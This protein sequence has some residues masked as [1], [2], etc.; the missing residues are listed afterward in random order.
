MAI[1][2]ISGPLLAKNLLRDGVDLAFETDLLYLDVKNGR[3]GVRKTN[4]A[5]ELDVNGTINANNLRVT[6]TGPG[7]G[8]ATLG[9][10]TINSGTIST[11]VGPVTIQPS[12]NDRINLVGDTTV[13]GNFHATGNI[14]ADGNIILGNT[15]TDIVV[16]DAEIDSDIIPTPGSNHTL[17]SQDNPW[18]AAFVDSIIANAL[19]NS[20]G[21]MSITPASGLLEINGDIR[22]RTTNPI[23]TAPVVTNVLYVTMDG[24]DTNDGRAEDPSRAC[25]TIGGAIRS[26]YYRPGTMI[27]VRSGRY[28]ENNPLLLQPNTAIVGDDLRT[29][30]IEPINKTQDLFHVQSGC[31]LAQ[32]QFLNGRSGLLPGVYASGSNRG[33]FCAA[34]PPQVSGKKIDVYQS[35]YIQNCTNQSGPWLIDGTMF[36]PNQTVQIPQ[37]VGLTTFE[38]NTNTLVVT[39]STGTIQVGMSINSGPQ[40]QGFLNARTLVLANKEFIKDQV[41]AFVN[42]TYPTFT[43]EQAK[44]ARDVGIIVENVLYDA[45]FGG[46]EKSVEAGLAYYDGVINLIEGQ[47]TQ[48]TAAINYINTLSQYII[49]NEVAPVISTA[50][51]QI[52]N[53]NLT[54]GDVASEE[55]TAGISI[56]AD[57]INNGPSVAPTIFKSSTPDNPLVS[58]EILLQANRTL[59]QEE[60]TAYVDAMYPNH[61]YDRS[62]CYRDVGLIVDAVSQDVLVG[63]NTKSLEAALSYYTGSKGNSSVA[64]QA[65]VNNLELIKKIILEGPSAAPTPVVGPNLGTGY[66]NAQDL[67]ERNTNFIQ[68]EVSAYVRSLFDE[69]FRLTQAQ[70]N[71]CYRDIGLI[72]SAIA[73][74]TGKGGNAKSVEAGLA[75]YNGNVSLLPGDQPTKTAQ[76]IDYLIALSRNIVKNIKNTNLYSTTATQ[77][78]TLAPATFNEVT[79]ATINLDLITDIITSGPDVAAVATPINLELTTNTSAIYAFNILQANRNFLSEEVTGYI[80]DV[81]GKGF[82]YDEYKCY[83]DTGLIVDSL[84]YDLLYQGNTQAIFAGLQYWTQGSSSIPNEQTTTTN[85]INYARDLAKRVIINDVITA[86][87][88]STSQIFDLLNPGDAASTLTVETLFNTVTNIISNG[89][90]GVTNQIIPNVEQSVDTGVLNSYALLQANKSFIENEVIAYVDASNQSFTYNKDLC[91]RDVGLIVDALA[92]DLLFSTSSQATFAG[93]QY[94]NQAGYT[95]DIS[96]E[97]TTTTNAIQYVRDLAVKIV[98]NDTT[99]PRYQTA[100]AQYTTSTSGT[101][102][103][104]QTVYDNF[105]Q[106]LDIL[107]NG[108]IGVSDKIVPNRLTSSTNTNVQN[109][110]ELLQSNKEYIEREAVA[111]VEATK[112]RGFIYDISKCL[113]DVGYMVDS[114]SFDVLYGGNKQS[115]QSGVYYYGFSTTSSAVPNE[116][117]QVTAAYNYIKEISNYII[118]GQRLPT[119]YQNTISQVLSASAGTTTEAALVNASVDNITNIVNTGPAGITPTPISLT[120]STDPNVINGAKLLSANRD[121]LKAEVIAYIDYLYPQG[122]T[123]DRVKCRRDVNYIIDCVSFDLLNGGNRQSIQAGVYYY[124]FNPSSSYLTYEVAQAIAAYNHINYISRDII[125]GIAV[126]TSTGNTATQVI[127]PD[128]GTDVEAEFIA[129]DINII[130]D[131]IANGPSTA[132]PREP[133]ALT[134]SA[135]TNVANAYAQLRANRE[136]IQAE[137]IAYVESNFSQP[138]VFDKLKCTRD[139]KLIIDSIALD[140]IY[141]GNTQSTFAGLQYWAQG[142]SAIPAEETTTTNAISYTKS[143][144]E[145]LVGSVVIAEIIGDRFDLIVNIIQSGTDGVTDIIVPN[146]LPSRNPEIINAYETLISN[147]ASLQQQTV[148]WVNTNNPGFVYNTSTCY[149]DVGYIIECV[150]FDLLHGGNRQSVQAGVYYYG[151]DE[152]NT[153]VPDE[154]PQTTAAYT[155]LKS[156]ITRVLQNQKVNRTYQTIYNQVTEPAYMAETSLIPGEESI[157]ANAITYLNTLSQ[158]VITNTPITKKYTTSTQA[159]Y[160]EFEGGYLAGPAVARNYSIIANI[161]QN[162]PSVAPTAYQGSGLFATTGVSSNDVRESPKVLEITTQT[163]NTYTVKISGVTQ[164][165]VYNGTL[166]FGET[167]VFPIQNA[168][169][170][171]LSLEYTGDATTWDRRKIDPIGAMGGAL[172]D[173]GV[174]SDRSPIQSFVFDAFTQVNQGG[175]GVYVTNNGYAQLVSVFTI[176][177]STAVQ[178]DNGGI[179]SITNSNSNF[180]DQ[181]LVAKGYGKREFSGTVYNPPFP[182]YQPNGEYYPAGFYPKNGLVEIFVPDS[183]NRPHIA[184]VM[185]VEPP[186]NYINEQG[187]SGFLNAAPSMPTLTT[188]TITITGIDT[189]GIAVGNSVFIRDQFGNTSYAA[190]GTTVV[191]VNYQSITLNKGLISGGGDI[192]NPNF[193]NLYFCGNA[194][195]TVL[196]SSLT[197]AYNTTPYDTVI[198]PD[199][200]GPESDAIDYIKTTVAGYLSAASVET[201]SINF[202]NDRFDII[203]QI[204]TATNLT[205]AESVVSNPVKTGTNPVGASLAI[206]TINANIENVVTST[207]S[208]INSTY[209]ALDY[210]Q[211]KCSRDIRLILRQVI[212]DLEFGGNYYSTYAG[213]SYWKRLGTHHVVNLEEAVNNTALFPDGAIVNFY[214]RSYMSASGYLFEYVGAGANYGALPQRGIADPVQTKEVIQLNNGKVFFTSTDQNGDFRIGPGLVVSQST[215]VLSGRT[216][217]KSLFANLTPFILAIEGS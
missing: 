74:D 17:G 91:S 36:V 164:G 183:A 67:L 25:K 68:T 30:S 44:C 93:L 175:R 121:F 126:T 29:T 3:I 94:W 187:F 190:T 7:T 180:G 45:A 129:R 201:A 165:P 35:P 115:I 95:G 23:G 123:Y 57:I 215:G 78:L 66:Y 80:D 212:Y 177:C 148:D 54:G 132:Y 179:C 77:V 96:N 120:P 205:L 153:N 90:A 60:T 4:P 5:Y 210:N 211:D 150:A 42:T 106:I 200:I 176:F 198:P 213:L 118:T 73:E 112:T 142:A 37:A 217:T 40:D 181:C 85:A 34:F 208:Y 116:Q 69:T 6:Y 13:T 12:G 151:F 53:T 48:T 104:S 71:L 158:L 192:D 2:R 56:I 169:A 186:L 124:G 38:A 128:V 117:I 86:L 51:S 160:P 147:K 170:E 64:E 196:S 72:V 138:F 31:Y 20:Q 136:F 189:S 199:Q 103:E 100:V 49:R 75:Y 14:S 89:T 16:F 97:L 98:T 194:Y 24:D 146:G 133:I 110:Y 157:T 119:Q 113:R 139:T 11:T 204:V 161:V 88:T 143:L 58:A 114:V 61:V 55:I 70:Q 166:Y 155:Y 122:F 216:F 145:T 137:V 87:Q 159:I 172:V 185:E 19:S 174:V 9:K 50:T 130:T 33:A 182:T 15:A 209:P 63:G 206:S 152:N 92:Q 193:F 178:V 207:I 46:N 109:A 39:V 156:L 1:G 203:N 197:E 141:E 149:R 21:N 84:A 125:K 59:L 102:A 52:I 108:T 82:D 188:G 28:L 18:G 163:G 127:L 154:I 32:M 171:E 83:R 107:V 10:L 81:F 47:Q 214:Q 202:V 79:S 65:V 27:R 144:A 8:S 167:G 191:D 173:G 76:A 22:A 195:Y 41:I 162:G 105:N 131:I 135:D 134:G 184:L 168:A 101:V 99:G 62:F 111:F 26:P 140:L 43:Y